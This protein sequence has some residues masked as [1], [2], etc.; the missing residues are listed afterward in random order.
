MGTYL[1]F[2]R[3]FPQRPARSPVAVAILFFSFLFPC[4]AGA[5]TQALDD[6]SNVERV[7]T[8]GETQSYDIKLKAGDF[9][10]LSVEPLVPQLRVALQS[11]T[12][13]EIASRMRWDLLPYAETIS[14]IAEKEGTYRLVI[15]SQ[16]PKPARYVVR[17]LEHRPAASGDVDRIEAERLFAEAKKLRGGQ[18]PEL[19][20]DAIAALQRASGLFRKIGDDAAV[21]DAEHLTGVTLLMSASD[22]RGSLPHFL[23]GLALRQCLPDGSARGDSL[24]YLGILYHLLGEPRKAITFFQSALPYRNP[25]SPRL[26]AITLRNLADMYEETGDEEGLPLLLSIL[27]LMHDAGEEV[28]EGYIEESIALHYNARGDWQKALEH[29]QQG[30]RHFRNAK[31]PRGE[32]FALF[33]LGTAYEG[34][35]E[36]ERALGYYEK[37]LAM[38]QEVSEPVLRAEALWQV[39]RIHRELRHF[40]RALELQQQALELYRTSGDRGME[41]MLLLTLGKTHAMRGDQ[42][43]ALTY[44]AEAL[45]ISRAVEFRNVEGG[46][47]QA[48]AQSQ[49]ELGKESEALTAASQAVDI[50]RSI[51]AEADEAATRLLRARIERAGGKLDAAR[52]D[53]EASIRLTEKVRG[54]IS[55]PETRATFVASA[56]ETYDFYIDLLMHLHLDALALRTSEQARARSLIDLLAESRIGA[57]DRVKPARIN[58]V[59]S[60]R[61]RISAKAQAQLKLAGS[62]NSA[63][64]EVIKREL[65]ELNSEYEQVTAEIRRADPA[66]AAV[67]SPE[68]LDI[69]QIQREIVDSSSVLLEYALGETRS[70]LWVVTPTRL[71]SYELPPRARIEASVR[72]AYQALSSRSEG[73]EALAAVS[74]MILAPASAVIRAKRLVVVPD[75]ALQYLPFA[76]LP[77]PESGK[78]L[79][80]DHEIVTL[81]S[82]SAIAVLRRHPRSQ[83]NS[84]VLAVFADPVFDRNDSRLTAQMEGPS[85]TDSRGADDAAVEAE[86]VRS[87]RESGLSN[88]PRLPF[89]RRE[90]IAVLSLVAPSQRTEALD[91]NA[92]RRTVLSVDLASYR[93]VHFATHGL[94]NNFHPELSGIV[95]SMVDEKG[96]E[97]NGFLSTA[98]V[99]N[100]SLAADLVVLSGCRT[101]LGKEIR[102]EGIAGLTR[103][104]MYAGSPRVV[105]SLW[106]VNDAATAE[107]MKRFYQEMLG[108]ERRPPA[109]ALRAAQLSMRQQARWSAPYYWAAFV[110]QGEWR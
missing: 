90:A 36:L 19:I 24:D 41:S 79:I 62:G 13:Q 10:R 81:P 52:A 23:T 95:L 40:D 26:V 102:G 87:A 85:P 106:N 101:G 17:V 91:F 27:D 16:S 56:W 80:A 88:L 67:T 20:R 21:A 83:K 107:L 44:Y 66:L 8:P 9:A 89:T 72:T 38:C 30:L 59:R 103:A 7:I 18:R 94:L 46:T 11:P 98:D 47:L 6:T 28:G 31:H 45:P 93:F 70:F 1:R 74:K 71:F 22:F 84:K 57:S 104:F 15:E 43:K 3:M 77:S 110:I 32:V 86:L 99:F 60:L 92:S 34:M 64:A 105:A 42:A 2:S 55:A 4:L 61:E 65:E 35:G 29:A 33:G 97:Q 69:A 82:A 12:G 49:F 63:Q 109:A 51:G 100:L 37:A 48:I 53:A 78:P 50:F 5:Q 75:G 96:R 58:R 39:G 68:P 54:N 14:T 76:A 73:T 108:P 25:Q